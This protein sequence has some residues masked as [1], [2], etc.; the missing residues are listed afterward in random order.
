MLDAAQ[1]LNR[2]LSGQGAAGALRGTIPSEPWQQLLRSKASGAELLA[3][4]KDR[5]VKASLVLGRQDLSW[6][7]ESLLVIA[8][9]SDRSLTLVQSLAGREESASSPASSGLSDELLRRRELR[10]AQRK[11]QRAEYQKG[12]AAQAK[13]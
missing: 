13:R 3:Y 5:L 10:A 7:V 8:D 1:E 9:V 2:T 4:A 11:L 12:K 6:S